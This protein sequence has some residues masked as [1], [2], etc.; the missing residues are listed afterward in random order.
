MSEGRLI[1]M[2]RV[3]DDGSLVLK[4]SATA[5][6]LAMVMQVIV[7]AMLDMEPDL[8]AELR[9]KVVKAIVAGVQA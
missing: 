3:R 5:T 4:H 2:A 7:P 9:D 8:K 6:E 1:L